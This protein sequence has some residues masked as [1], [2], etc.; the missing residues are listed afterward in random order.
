[1]PI[2]EVTQQVKMVHHRDHQ[3][4]AARIFGVA[5]PMA[6]VIGHVAARRGDDVHRRHVSARISDG[7]G[8]LAQHARVIRVLAPDGEA[9]GN[10]WTWTGHQ[11]PLSALAGRR[12][13][14]LVAMIAAARYYHRQLTCIRSATNS[15]TRRVPKRA[16]ERAGHSNTF[17][18]PR[19][20]QPVRAS[21]VGAQ[22]RGAATTTT[23]NAGEV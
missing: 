18:H 20:P 10:A 4:A 17:K 14:C 7:G 3:H 1:M 15:P 21:L 16:L 13:M 6:G 22:G 23:H 5:H 2:G 9:V 12:R 8:D 19:T 11:F